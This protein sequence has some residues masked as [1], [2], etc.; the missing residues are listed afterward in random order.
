MIHLCLAE[1]V[2]AEL[3][4]PIMNNRDIF[5]LLH[6]ETKRPL[7]TDVAT[8]TKWL[9]EANRLVDETIIGSDIFISTTFLGIA[10]SFDQEDRPLL[11]ATIVNGGAMSGHAN[12]YATWDEAVS[13]HH[14]IVG[15]VL[16]AEAG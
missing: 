6:P 13:G 4:N 12:H 5:Y 11:F 10:Y 8:W 15:I 9:E 14:E 2:S 7:K 1:L 3:S 16:L